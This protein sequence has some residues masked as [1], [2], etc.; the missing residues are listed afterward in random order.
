MDRELSKKV[1]LQKRIKK[2]LSGLLLMLLFFL[3]GW[4]LRHLLQSSLLRD[5]IRTAIAELGAMEATLIASGVVLPE[6]YQVLTSAIQ[7]K[8]EEVYIRAG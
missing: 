2:L 8:I 1:V 6:Y 4:G 3:G 5:R 7:S